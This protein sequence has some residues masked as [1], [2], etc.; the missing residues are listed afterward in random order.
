M[1]TRLSLLSVLLATAMSGCSTGQIPKPELLKSPVG[2]VGVSTAALNAV[3]F[4][5]RDTADG[6]LMCTAP[7]PDATFDQATEVALTFGLVN[8]TGGTSTAGLAAGVGE[9]EQPLGGRAPSVLIARE[10]M[11]R[12]CETSFNY[13]LSKQEHLA[14]YQ[15]TLS[16]IKDI[17]ASSTVEGTAT[18]ANEKSLL[19]PAVP[20]TQI[21]SISTDSFSSD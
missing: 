3:H 18:V 16:V 9:A 13:K 21:G 1:N 2:T 15:Q 6:I 10:L 14:L 19:I 11:F 7:E 8:V 12:L 20:T 17:G 4:L 5:E